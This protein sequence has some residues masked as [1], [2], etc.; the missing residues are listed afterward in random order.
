M[1]ATTNITCFRGEDLAFTLTMSPVVD[2][3]SWTTTLVVKAGDGSGD[4]LITVAG[5]VVGDGTAGQI[6]FTIPAA[7]SNIPPGVYSHT[8]ARTNTGSKAVL[9]EG[10]FT[11]KQNNAL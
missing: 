6:T 2:V 8:I 4:A 1:A 11:V 10:G 5:S 3:S 9:S 7:A